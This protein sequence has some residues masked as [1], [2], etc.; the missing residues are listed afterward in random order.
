[1]RTPCGKPINQVEEK[2]KGQFKMAPVKVAH[3]KR[4]VLLASSQRA[5]TYPG[6]TSVLL[7]MT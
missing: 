2:L 4:D 5:L 6:V 3:G 1:M 7:M